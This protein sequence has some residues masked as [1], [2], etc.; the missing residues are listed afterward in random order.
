MISDY[1]GTIY[2]YN[3][4]SSE[5]RLIM[6]NWLHYVE[7]LDYSPYYVEYCPLCGKLC[8]HIIT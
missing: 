1:N 7:Y 5:R 3:Q 8:V 2:K 4:I 6:R